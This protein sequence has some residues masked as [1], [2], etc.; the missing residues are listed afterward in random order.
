M[1]RP[2]AF[3]LSRALDLICL[4]GDYNKEHIESA[5]CS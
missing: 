5:K 1:Y 4:N 2:R 3:E